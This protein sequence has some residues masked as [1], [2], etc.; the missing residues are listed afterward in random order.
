MLYTLEDGM[1]KKLY[2]EKLF[3]NRREKLID[4]CV[5]LQR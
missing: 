1:E 4:M 5:D 3:S 2:I